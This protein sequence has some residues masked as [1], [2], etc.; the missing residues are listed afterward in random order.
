M[1]VIR[2]LHLSYLERL[3][4]PDDIDTS[5]PELVDAGISLLLDGM[6]ANPRSKT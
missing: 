2:L 3:F 5:D 6:T 4:E 1:D